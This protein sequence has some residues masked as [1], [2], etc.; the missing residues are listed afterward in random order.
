[1]CVCMEHLN[2]YSMIAVTEITQGILLEALH[3]YE[4]VYEECKTIE[5]YTDILEILLKNNMQ[6][7]LCFYLCNENEFLDYDDVNWLLT[8]NSITMVYGAYIDYTAYALYTNNE[9]PKDGLLPRIE[10]LKSLITD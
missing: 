10:L 2:Q 6:H 4:K 1:M 8:T 9:N 7:G 5:S 3:H